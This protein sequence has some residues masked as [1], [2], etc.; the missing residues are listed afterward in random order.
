MAER[1]GIAKNK[2]MYFPI[3]CNLFMK[4]LILILIHNRTNL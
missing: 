2:Y 4:T 3:V 1:G